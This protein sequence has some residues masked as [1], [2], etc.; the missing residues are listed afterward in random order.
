MPARNH[1]RGRS[2]GTY[3]PHPIACIL[4]IMA[5]LLL[6]QWHE[7]NAATGAEVRRLQ[8]DLIWTG[9]Y[10]GTADGRLGP[11]TLEAIRSF[12]ASLGAPETGDLSEAQL[13][14]LSAQAAALEA[15]V[16]WT[17]Y[18]N[19]VAGYRIGYPAAILP[20]AR[21]LDPTGQEFASEDGSVMLATIVTGPDSEDSLRRSYDRI[22]ADNA[23]GIA[24][25]I[26][27]PTWFAVSY[28]IGGSGYYV[29]SRRKPAATARY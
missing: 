7:A 1:A 14:Q 5:T 19:P 17:I 16:G 20:V 10:E 9:H 21:S 12:Q 23:D 11:G 22:V 26:F 8:W 28:V 15:D 6:A 25:K 13:E 29:M 4:L 24:Y 18:E 3:F 27:R 2:A